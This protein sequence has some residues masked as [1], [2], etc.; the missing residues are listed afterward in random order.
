MTDK[1]LRLTPLTYLLL[2]FIAGIVAFRYNMPL[3]NIL[4]ASIGIILSST[5]IIFISIRYLTNPYNNY[6]KYLIIIGSIILLFYIGTISIW[7]QYNYLSNNFRQLEHI[8]DTREKYIITGIVKTCPEPLLM[9]K[10][11]IKV[12]VTSIGH[13]SNKIKPELLLL[14][15]NGIG[16]EYVGPG[17]KIKF[18]AT[19]K[20]IHNYNTPGSFDKRL[21][22]AQRGI[23]VTA[24][25]PGPLYIAR[26][27]QWKPALSSLWE[28]HKWPIAIQRIRYSLLNAMHENLSS[29]AFPLA[30]ALVLG[31][32]TA[33]PPE[34]RQAFSDV[35]IGHLLA[36]SGLHMALVA[37]LLGGLIYW[38]ILCTPGLPLYVNARKIA[39]SIS[40]LSLFGYCALAGFSPSATRALIM[41]S[42]FCV[43]LLFDLPQTALNS[44]AIAA[45]L[46]LCLNP[47]SL[48]SVSFQL[49]FTAVFFLIVFATSYK[50]KEINQHIH[51]GKLISATLIAF[52]TTSPLTTF[53]FQRLSLVALPS[54]LIFL[55]IVSTAIL[56]PLLI[57]AFLYQFIP[58]LS[59]HIW[60]TISPVI[61]LL[62]NTI[63]YIAS[64]QYSAIWVTDINLLKVIVIYS[65]ILLTIL[66][67]KSNISYKK[68]FTAG[69]ILIATVVFLWPHGNIRGI[70]LHVLDVGQGTAQVIEFPEHKVMVVDAGPIYPSGFDLGKA[71]VG[72]FLRTLG[73]KRIDFLVCSHPETDHYGGMLSLIKEFPV[74]CF[75]Q[76]DIKSYR[77]KWLELMRLLKQKGIKKK[78]WRH[79]STVD[80]EHS[81]I[82][83][84]VSSKNKYLKS[85]NSRCLVLDIAYNNKKLLIP[86]DIDIKREAVL[87]HTDKIG[88]QDCIV[89]PHHGSRSSLNQ[90]F[91]RAISPKI[92]IISVGWLNRLHLP[93]K[94]VLE[95]Y[96]SVGTEIYRTDT[97]GTVTISVTNSLIRTRCFRLNQN[98]R[99]F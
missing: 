87:I 29:D 1:N 42:S 9:N 72:P 98:L 65:I 57:A 38:I 96:R 7:F 89:I 28:P 77:G 34:I 70:R 27:C 49:S 69:A 2:P 54:N 32:K 95:A 45:W 5:L 83:L 76:P 73:Y 39:A 33:L 91:I 74:G 55:P 64:Y 31:I 81:Q 19:L 30:V 63:K 26:L 18:I 44:L 99:E 61:T 97:N 88:H 22:W 37:L 6:T 8:A 62:I 14:T 24:F 12:I 11:R 86:G 71:V 41:V 58:K 23:K 94:R 85:A 40:L 36:I 84:F 50:S 4:P 59:I 79:N 20:T 93:N 35:G 92:G 68:I 51:I 13:P 21:W 10:T 15:V 46:I 17:D 53:Y 60:H 3:T 16:P 52:I 25:C 43:A 67:I 47:L 82:H 56:P 90:G 66:V 78:I 48:F 75:W 80:I